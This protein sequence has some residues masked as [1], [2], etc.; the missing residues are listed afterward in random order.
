M[1]RISF[2]FILLLLVTTVRAEA[3]GKI[4]TPDW[5]EVTEVS[6]NIGVMGLPMTVYMFTGAYKKEDILRFYRKKWQ[7]VRKDS[8]KERYVEPWHI[9]SRLKGNLLYTVQVQQENALMVRGYLAVSDVREKEPGFRVKKRVPTLPG[10]RMI[11]DYSM[12]DP[13]KKGRVLLISNGHSIEANRNYYEQYYTS[14]GWSVEMS[15][16]TP[17]SSVQ[18]FRYRNKESHIVISRL[19]GQTQV[20]MNLVE[21]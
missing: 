20:V 15:R 14:N 11:N 9:L 8:V 7:T 13:G 2:L 6:S 3:V 1:N 4:E 12:T 10:S 18:L 17:E 19:Y 21:Q 5:L 16:Q